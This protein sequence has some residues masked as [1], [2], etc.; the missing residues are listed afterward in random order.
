[1]EGECGFNFFFFPFPFPLPLSQGT[2]RVTGKEI[3]I[4]IFLYVD[5]VDFVHDLVDPVDGFARFVGSAGFARFA[6]DHVGCRVE[7]NFFLSLF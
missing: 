1:M 7:L 6:A 4:S 5:F 3:R 2:V